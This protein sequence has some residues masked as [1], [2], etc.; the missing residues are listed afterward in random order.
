MIAFR[1]RAEICAN[2]FL[3]CNR[4]SLNPFSTKKSTLKLS[5]ALIHCTAIV[6]IKRFFFSLFLLLS[7]WLL[8]KLFMHLLHFGVKNTSF[9]SLHQ[10]SNE[11]LTSHQRVKSS[12]ANASNEKGRNTITFLFALCSLATRVSIHVLFSLCVYTSRRASKLNW[13]R[14]CSPYGFL[15]HLTMAVFITVTQTGKRVERKSGKVLKQRQVLFED[16]ASMLRQDANGLASVWLQKNVM[17]VLCTCIFLS[18]NHGYKLCD[19]NFAFDL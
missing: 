2:H 18:E 5:I 16:K 7:S 6:F 15:I 11:S 17:F 8:F 9:F 12:Y 19:D 10:V 1:L 14:F 3:H 4:G 13:R